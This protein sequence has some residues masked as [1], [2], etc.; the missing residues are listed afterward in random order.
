LTYHAVTRRKITVFGGSQTR[1]NI[2]IDDICDLYRDVLEADA[3]AIAG[4]TFNAGF[5]N[6]TITELA[7]TIRDVVT[8]EFPDG[9]PIT[10]ETTPTNDLRSY[11]VTSD[12]IERELGFRPRR[13]IED[14]VRDICRA[15]KFDRFAA[16]PEDD[17]YHNVRL[18]K[19][20]DGT[21]DTALVAVG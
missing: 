4:R 5:Q 18:M 14:A 7:E 15:F 12:L 19:R 10:I 20:R 16:G 11:R 21:L 9:T 2:H 6:R 17:R 13:T 3:S 8:R 1:P